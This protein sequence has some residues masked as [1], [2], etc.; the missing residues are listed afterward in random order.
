MKHQ[1]FFSCLL[2]FFVSITMHAYDFEVDGLRYTILS[3]DDYTCA[4][5]EMGELRYTS[6]CQGDIVIPSIVTNPN[7]G[8]RYSVAEIA[9]WAFEQ[10]F[11]ITSVTIPSS[12]T[13]I[14]W[15]AFSD[16][17]SITS[18]V[19]PQG[20]QI[21]ENYAFYRCSGLTSIYIPSSVSTIGG[22]PIQSCDNLETIEVDERNPYY[23]SR[24]GCNAIINSSTNELIVGCKNTF[25]PNTVES[26]GENAFYGCATLTSVNIPSSVKSIG[27]NAFVWCENLSSVKIGSGVTT[28][29]SAAFARCSIKSLHIPASVISIANDAFVG[30]KNG[31]TTI[32]VDGNNTTYDSRNSCNAIIETATNALILG[33]GATVIPSSVVAIGD[34]AFAYCE[35]LVTID[36]PVGVTS[37]GESA[38]LVCPNLQS[39]IIPEGVT[40]LPLSVFCECQSLESIV[41]PSTLKSISQNAFQG[42]W[43]LKSI[44]IPKN[45]NNINTL[46][47]NFYYSSGEGQTLETITV[48]P[49]N[50]TFD[51]RDN[52]NAIIRTADNKLWKGCKNTVIPS[53]VQ[54]IES[55]AFEGCKD[56]TDITIPEGVTSM[57]WSAFAGSGLKHV[58]L[59]Q[60]LTSIGNYAFS[61]CTSLEEIRLPRNV[62]SIGS[63]AFGSCSNI[64]RVVSEI[65]NP[66]N[67]NSNTF[68]SSSQG[69]PGIGD[70]VILYVPV[71]SRD[72]YLACQGWD[73]FS[74]I[75]EIEMFNTLDALSTKI[76]KGGIGRLAITM[77]NEQ[78]IT[79]FQFVVGLPEGVSLTKC[80]LTDRKKSGHNISFAPLANGN[81]Q[82]TC[83][84][85]SSETF[86]GNEGALVNLTLTVDKNTVEDDYQVTIK[87]I[88]LTTLDA[89]AL[90]PLDVTGTLTVTDV[91]LGDT[92]ADGRVT[93]TDAVAI[94]NYILNNPPATFVYEAADVNRDTRVSITDAVAIVNMI[95]AGQN[96]ANVRTAD[97]TNIRVADTLDPQ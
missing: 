66:F 12:V 55:Y 35:D 10:C 37:I 89:V 36:I 52:C 17:N 51:S 62:S 63:Y 31:L 5:G 56:L 92:N 76:A 88:E 33:C 6:V 29:K 59:P 42:C 34:Y 94:V 69:Y 74:D 18:I 8:I 47:F 95:L 91:L 57:G 78:P 71:G 83:I 84:S 4:I 15:G 64:Q 50:T 80:E 38:F 67:I 72:K 81:Y 26:I 86:S 1:H 9:R 39:A 21:I 96:S 82:V 53:T 54:S 25:I 48:D 70:N 16:C 75:V 23:D 97:S 58:A 13:A 7:T 68:G 27:K 28:I 93:I 24:I 79:A 20:V 2:L 61:M 40:K 19:I 43:S 73:V 49:E 77:N 14:K 32:T 60:S 11:Y 44:H 87:D 90:T 30:Q 41:F 85:L 22:N 65:E 45:V 46:A 3:E